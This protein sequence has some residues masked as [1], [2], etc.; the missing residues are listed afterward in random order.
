M[1]LTGFFFEKPD[2]LKGKGVRIIPLVE[3]Q[4]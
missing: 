3:K 2:D 4:E 1:A